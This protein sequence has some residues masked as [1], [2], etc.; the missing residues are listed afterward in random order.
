MVR[1]VL[2]DTAADGGGAGD[3]RGAVEQNGAGAAL[4][5]AAAVLGAGY[6]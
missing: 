5:F 3:D 1:M 2:P 4:A 6:A